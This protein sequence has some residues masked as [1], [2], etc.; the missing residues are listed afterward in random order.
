MTQPRPSK[1]RKTVNL[2]PP[3]PLPSGSTGVEEYI[4]MYV[5]P[6]EFMSEWESC[7]ADSEY[8]KPRSNN[9]LKP[10]KAR[11]NKESSLEPELGTFME[12]NP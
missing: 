12:V 6:R 2:L 4:P 8:E 3:P 1:G 10:T 5:E 9:G 7:D 11:H